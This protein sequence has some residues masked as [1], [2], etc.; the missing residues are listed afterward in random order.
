MVVL[1]GAGWTVQIGGKWCD[2]EQ[3]MG[4]DVEDGMRQGYGRSLAAMGNDGKGPARETR[5]M[6]T[7][8]SAREERPQGRRRRNEKANGRTRRRE[9]WTVEKGT[10][11]RPQRTGWASR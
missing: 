5:K 2:D 7:E 6:E 10:V 1:E 4:V 11:R 9:V 3:R 8:E